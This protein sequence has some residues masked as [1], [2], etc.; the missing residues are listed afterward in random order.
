MQ[1]ARYGGFGIAILSGESSPLPVLG[2]D[3]KIEALSPRP[4]AQH[5]TVDI[6]V[7]AT[8]IGQDQA[9]SVGDIRWPSRRAGDDQAKMN[10]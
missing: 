6:L 1:V 7:A 2:D 10:S 3:E 5:K 8:N 9:V 4:V